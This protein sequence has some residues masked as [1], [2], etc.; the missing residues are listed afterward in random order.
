MASYER[1]EAGGEWETL[2]P[3]QIEDNTVIFMM[4]DV[5]TDYV[6]FDL[7]GAKIEYRRVREV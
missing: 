6:T 3:A 5:E 4:D 2:S 7:D 1:R